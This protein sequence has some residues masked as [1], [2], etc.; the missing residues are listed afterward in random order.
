MRKIVKEAAWFWYKHP[1]LS[2]T[3]FLISLILFS[4]GLG[5]LMV[6]SLNPDPVT[7]NMKIVEILAKTGLPFILVAI[8]LIV[9]WWNKFEWRKIPKI[10]KD[11]AQ[12]ILK[13]NPQLN[14][15]LNNHAQLIKWLELYENFTRAKEDLIR[16]TKQLN[17]LPEFEKNKE[18]LEAKIKNLKSKL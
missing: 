2:A 6:W 5:M 4:M 12:K 18:K 7:I 10:A 14:P 8:I 16:I 15:P 13:E 1:T 17:K 9:G 11:K 3:M